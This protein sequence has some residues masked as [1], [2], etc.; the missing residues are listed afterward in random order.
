M[1]RRSGH[2]GPPLRL[3]WSQGLHRPRKRTQRTS[4]LG[5]HPTKF[6]KSTFA[7]EIRWCFGTQPQFRFLQGP[8]RPIGPSWEYSCHQHDFFRL[9]R[10]GR[11]GAIHRTHNVFL[12]HASGD[13]GDLHASCQQCA[14]QQQHIFVNHG[15]WWWWWWSVVVY[16]RI[17]LNAK[18]QGNQPMIN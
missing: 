10:R 9:K 7:S 12:R 1:S 13:T 15:W 8:S 18:G 4:G 14:Q 5:K 3:P 6:S 11:P 2:E 17:Y 16:L